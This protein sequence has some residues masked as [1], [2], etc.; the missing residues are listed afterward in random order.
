VH[1]QYV[2]QHPELVTNPPEFRELGLNDDQIGR[3][4]YRF[5]SVPKQF[6]T[7]GAYRTQ[8]YYS[9]FDMMTEIEAGL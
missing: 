9:Q 7:A 5:L 4:A 1:D 2:Q 6:T 8:R 3:L